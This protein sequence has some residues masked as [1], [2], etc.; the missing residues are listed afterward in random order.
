VSRKVAESVARQA[1][2]EGVARLMN[3][4]EL[5]TRIDAFMWK[6]AYRPYKRLRN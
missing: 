6:P 5:Q 3:D 1:Q 2:K 4:H